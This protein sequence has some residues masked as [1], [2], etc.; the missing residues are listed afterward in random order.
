MLKIKQCIV[1]IFSYMLGKQSGKKNLLLFGH[2]QNCLDSPPCCFGH[3]WA[4]LL[5]KCIFFNSAFGL[6]TNR[7]RF[8][9]GIASLSQAVKGSIWTLEVEVGQFVYLS[10]L[11]R[12]QWIWK[13]FKPK[14]YIWRFNNKK[15][16]FICLQLDVVESQASQSQGCLATV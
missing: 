10:H 15:I 6:C 2:C 8:F 7:S 1:R 3:L 5:K 9:Y 14:S 11:W 13:W 12:L 16:H 4:T